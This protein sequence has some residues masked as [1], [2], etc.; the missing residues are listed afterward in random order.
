[1][2]KKGYVVLKK[3]YEYDDSY[4]NAYSDGGGLP[5]IFFFDKGMAI[6]SCKDLEVKQHLMENIEHYCGGD[7]SCVVGNVSKLEVFLCSLV[8][9][10]G[11]IQPSTRYYE[12]TKYSLHPSANP[13]EISK[14]LSF[15]N[16]YIF[17]GVVE[18][19]IDQSSFRD[20]VIN[21]VISEDL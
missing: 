11:P 7:I 3:G 6:A 4:Y 14:Y 20:E 19:N 15:F 21:H 13:E 12:V 2:N 5:E 9:K 16:D 17:Y 10:Y 1:M 8:D 18:T